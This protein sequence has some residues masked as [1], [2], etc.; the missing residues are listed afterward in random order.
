[1]DPDGFLLQSSIKACTSDSGASAA[2]LPL[3][4]GQKRKRG[5]PSKQ[6]IALREAAL[7]ALKAE[8][9]RAAEAGAAA[10]AVQPLSPARADKQRQ[11]VSGVRVTAA[12]VPTADLD[13]PAQH[14]PTTSPPAATK[15]AGGR[16]VSKHP[17]NQQGGVAAKA[18]KAWPASPKGRT[19]SPKGRALSPKGRLQHPAAVLSPASPVRDA[20]G[21]G[22]LGQRSRKS[23]AEEEEYTP[24][25]LVAPRKAASGKALK[26]IKKQVPVANQQK[27]QAAQHAQQ[28]LEPDTLVGI[29]TTAGVVMHAE[30]IPDSA[31]SQGQQAA[32]ATGHAASKKQV[33]EMEPRQI[34]VSVVADIVD[35]ALDEPGCARA[36]PW[37]KHLIQA[38]DMEAADLDGDEILEDAEPLANAVATV[39]Y[40]GDLTPAAAMAANQDSMGQ[41]GSGGT[42]QAT[43][44]PA[45]QAGLIGPPNAVQNRPHA[46]TIQDHIQMHHQPRSSHTSHHP[47]PNLHQ[48]AKHSQVQTGDSQAR[49][50]HSQPTGR[51]A[52]TGTPVDQ[53]QAEGS[54]QNATPAVSEAERRSGDSSGNATAVQHGVGHTG[55][56]SEALPVSKAAVVQQQQQQYHP[57]ASASDQGLHSNTNKSHLPGALLLHLWSLLCC[58]CCLR[59]LLLSAAL[60]FALCLLPWTPSLLRQI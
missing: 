51:G 59:V 44:A 33:V 42:G 18:N 10:A 22:G 39:E 34:E 24:E 58:L 5:R 49:T 21:S 19:A 9:A 14:P 2:A 23:C 40:T 55:E 38:V 47:Q 6:D 56:S 8:E 60:V 1:M 30:P 4:P 53:G 45:E 52:P 16:P 26:R 13:P 12:P 17:A 3:I 15:G 54:S 7:A 36:R 28:D 25:D 41:T 48:A 27:L 32:A 31:D 43:R 20:H 46:A 29:Q 37:T 11:G 50:G 35:I 57:T